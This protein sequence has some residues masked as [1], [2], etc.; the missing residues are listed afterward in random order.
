M[1]TFLAPRVL[2]SHSAATAAWALS[3]K[4]ARKTRGPDCAGRRGEV[5][6]EVTKTFS[7]EQ[8]A[9][10]AA[11]A[12]SVSLS[13]KKASME[14]SLATAFLI[15]LLA[16][17]A[18]E[19]VGRMVSE[20]FSPPIPPATLIWLTAALAPSSEGAPSGASSPEVL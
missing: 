3:P 20:T 15:S 7:L 18:E 12:R 1:A 16:T 6:P 17:L 11:R 4:Q 19:G 9:L 2:A 8:A 5:A 13:P 14:G 10:P